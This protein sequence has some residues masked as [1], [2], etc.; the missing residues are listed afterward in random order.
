M[1]LHY[2]KQ[3]VNHFL[4]EKMTEAASRKDNNATSPLHYRKD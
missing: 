2:T 4:L 3:Q 1:G